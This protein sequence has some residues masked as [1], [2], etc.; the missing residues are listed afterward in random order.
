MT[1]GKVI[2]AAFNNT[3]LVLVNNIIP[4][5]NFL[6]IFLRNNFLIIKKK[7]EIDTTIINNVINGVC[8]LP[9]KDVDMTFFDP[10]K[11]IDI[12]VKTNIG[13]NPREK[14]TKTTLKVLRYVDLIFLDT[15]YARE[16]PPT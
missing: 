8:S 11:R 14:S 16:N 9:I 6:R 12:K 3:G 4:R 1:N 10:K 2:I 15:K 7:T 13:S 5:F